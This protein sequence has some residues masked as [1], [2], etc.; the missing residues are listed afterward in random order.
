LWRRKIRNGLS[1]AVCLFAALAVLAG[2]A[3]SPDVFSTYRKQAV[4]DSSTPEAQTYLREFVASVGADLATLLAKCNTE[5]AAH[6]T[7][8][9]ELVFKVDHWGEPK[10]ILVNPQTDVASCVASGFFY[11]KFPH[12]DARFEKTGLVLM[13]PIK[14]E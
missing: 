6:D 13:L 3:S 7:D 1:S 8:Q 4:R 9:F 12:P 11:F 10:A 5:S 14:V 2:C